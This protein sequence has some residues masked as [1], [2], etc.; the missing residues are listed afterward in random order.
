MPS[1]ASQS[2]LMRG[3]HFVNPSGSDT[4]DY[5]SDQRNPVTCLCEPGK[6]DC[7][8]KHIDPEQRE[9]VAATY[10]YCLPQAAR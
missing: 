6:N 7:E 2:P 3:C 5:M 1:M 8:S 10:Q 9:A 4:K